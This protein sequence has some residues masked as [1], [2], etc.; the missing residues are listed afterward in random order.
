MMLIEIR[1]SGIFLL[2]VGLVLVT[3]CTT[4]EAPAETPASEPQ[5]E[6]KVV[7][8]KEVRDVVFDSRKIFE[9]PAGD[10]NGDGAL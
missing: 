2:L 9:L 1:K 6:E 4:N 5:T 7:V 10:Y 3:G 8:E